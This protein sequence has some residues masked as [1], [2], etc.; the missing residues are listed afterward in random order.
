CLVE[1]YPGKI[2]AW[3]CQ[4]G[5]EARPDWIRDIGEHDRD[6]ACFL[7]QCGNGLS[8]LSEDHLGLQSDQLFR[9]SPVPIALAGSEAIVDVDTTYLRPSETLEPFPKCL[10]VRRRIGVVGGRARKPANAT[11]A[12]RCLLCAH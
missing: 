2:A 8:S 6:R 5:N 3:V 9:Q 10:Q 11:H 7:L 1:Q 4:V 12:L